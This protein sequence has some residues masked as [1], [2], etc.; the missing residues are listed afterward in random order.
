LRAAI[1]SPGMS[2]IFDDTEGSM[3]RATTTDIA[4]TL[5]V[6]LFFIL[7]GMADAFMSP[8]EII[9]DKINWRT[10]VRDLESFEGVLA[11]LRE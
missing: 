8:M 7:V 5:S 9:S 3:Q 1:T 4:Q 2:L 10:A 11:R 6:I